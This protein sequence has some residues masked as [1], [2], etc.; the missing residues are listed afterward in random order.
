VT[1]T[2]E[3]G[4]G[5]FPTGP[6]ITFAPDSDIAIRDGKA[7][8]EF[9][10]YH[11]GQT[12]IR[13]SSP[14]LAEA[15]LVITSLGA[16][17]FVPGLTSPATVRP[18][19]R[20]TQAPTSGSWQKFGLEN[21]TRTSSDTP[22][23]TGRHANDGSPLTQWQAAPTDTQP[24]LRI[25]LERVITVTAVR[26]FFTGA[27]TW[28]YRIEVSPDGEHDWRLFA[29][30]AKTEVENPWTS[31]AVDGTA[32]KGRYLRITLL[33]WPKGTAA[34]LGDV[35]ASGTLHQD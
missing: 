21:P 29:D 25:D 19:K 10:S 16:P 7:A 5:E 12:R 3:E 13:A 2:I 24:W 34:G 32:C 33:D 20:H 15:T 35:S 6:S 8:I 26:L 14:G 27:G 31:H 4:P 22:G 23:N 18:Y 11:A 9:R 28:S 17:K 1:L 30:A